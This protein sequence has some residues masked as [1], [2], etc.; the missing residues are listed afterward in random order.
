MHST[1]RPEDDAKKVGSKT[2]DENYPVH[3]QADSEVE[4]S[5]SLG[6]SF[7]TDRIAL[8]PVPT[9]RELSQV[10]KGRWLIGPE[11]A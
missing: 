10:M 4:A 6:Q 11:A 2:R 8:P 5:G 1:R 7:V 3:P 9:R